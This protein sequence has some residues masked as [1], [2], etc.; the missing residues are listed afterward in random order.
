[1]A[2]LSITR[3]C[4]RGCSYC[5][6]K[7]ERERDGVVDMPSDVFDRGVSFLERAG[8]PEVRLLGG[9]PTEHPEFREYVSRARQ[10]GFRVVVF[11]GGLIPENALEYIASLP[12]EDFQL[13]L[14]AA[15]PSVDPGGLV[16]QQERLCGILGDK[17]ML[18]INI[19]SFG[20]RPV[21]LLHWIGQYG[22]QRTLRVGLT[23]PTLGGSNAWLR[24]PN[25]RVVGLLEGLYAAAAQAGIHIGFDCGFTPCMFSESFVRENRDL[26]SA[27][28]TGDLDRRAAP[29]EGGGSPARP[30]R[31]SIGRCSS[32]IDVL[33]DGTCIACYALS[34]VL[35]IPL[36]ERADR[37]DLLHTF[38]TKLTSMVPSGVF[39]ACGR[40][41]Y[42]ENGMCDGGC[43][44][45]RA[46]RLRPDSRHLQGSEGANG[47]GIA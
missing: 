28:P 33:P 10:R 40:C 9:E 14:N 32:V 19:G 34:R 6:A 15:D 1:M 29:V 35:R 45:R 38:E 41:R 26:F 37:K 17:V 12:T 36:P 11:S 8:I 18:G 16:R 30:Q 23:H 31:A 21:H 44:A 46:M 3:R 22:L 27:P 43:R 7:H 24:I 25:P 39:R 4:R 42:L 47:E 13:I 2:N 5:F 20:Q